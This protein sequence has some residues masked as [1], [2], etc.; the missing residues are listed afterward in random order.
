MFKFVMAWLCAMALIVSGSAPAAAP[1]TCTLT[2]TPSTIII[3]Q[4]SVLTATCSPAA[5]SY[6]WTNAGFGFG[7]TVATGNVKPLETTTY[8]VVGS[9]ADGSGNT[10]SATVT[11]LPDTEPPTVP[12]G[13]SATGVSPVRINLAWT[14]ATDNGA[15]TAYKVYRNGDL[16]V[17][18]GNVTSYGDTGL[19][20]STSY[21]Y[22]VQACDAAGNC[23]AQSAATSAT[24]LPLLATFNVSDAA[25]LRAALLAAATDTGQD[26]VIALAAGTYATGGT[27]FG[28]FSNSRRALMLRGAEGTTRDQVVLDG[29]GASRVLTLDCLGGSSCGTVTLQGL[30]VRNGNASDGGGISVSQNL[31]LSNVT[32]SGNRASGSG[33]AIYGNLVIAN[34]SFFS[35]NT[36]GGNGGAIYGWGRL[37]NSLFNDNTA[38]GN[39][40]AIATFFMLLANSTFSGNAAGAH[41]SAIDI[42]GSPGDTLFNLSFYGYATSLIINSVFYGNAA[43]A[44][45]IETSNGA[46]LYNN[47]LNVGTDVAGAA[48]QP[49]STG[50]V[51]PGATS[52]FVDAANNDFRLVAGSPAIDAGL[53]PNSTTFGRLANSSIIASVRQALLTD[54]QGIARPT[55]GTTVDIGAYEF[56]PTAVFISQSTCLFN[57]AGSTFPGFF[58]PAGA[59]A[60]T[61][62]SYYFMYYPATNS[63]LATSSADYHLYY[64]GP[65]TNNTV[66]DLGVFS[67]WVAIAGCQ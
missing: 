64:L 42:Y 9:N 47:L 67:G 11:V 20:A 28:L 59:I 44:V 22:M 62:L 33:G 12:T 14:A 13:L 19:A 35:R 34:N 15:I 23:S 27:A 48:P 18:L 45:Y 55:P 57:W 50:N 5:T 52:P 30:T 6:A 10:A 60:G 3:G 66:F 29:G 58:S 2:A 17:T 51:A 25:G 7:P 53:D 40:G 8:S 56:V 46:T 4:S 32:V 24:T 63:F 26:V 43:P 54:L 41:G 39:G 37:T 31:E 21:S 38:G 49:Q 1:P 16:I 36:A 61:L 65:L